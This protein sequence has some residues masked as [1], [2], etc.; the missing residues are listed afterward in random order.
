MTATVRGLNARSRFLSRAARFGSGC[1]VAAFGVGEH[2]SRVED[3]EAVLVG[4]DR[5]EIH[6]GDLRMRRRRF[7]RRFRAATRSRRCRRRADRG[8]RAESE[9][10]EAARAS[11]TPRARQ[12]APAQARCPSSLRRT[13]RRA[14]PS[15]SGRIVRRGTSPRSAR[16]P[17]WPSAERRRPRSA[18]RAPWRRRLRRIRSNASRT[19]AS[20]ARLSSTPP[21]SLLWL[22][23]GD[24]TFSTTGNPIR[25]A[26]C[27]AS[28]AEAAT[29][30]TTTGR[31]SE[32]RIRLLSI[33]VRTDRPL[34][35]ADDI[36][37]ETIE[38]VTLV[39]YSR[40]RELFEPPGSY[41]AR[42]RAESSANAVGIAG[43]LSRK[44]GK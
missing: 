30:G 37:D 23:S 9:R 35:R 36:T 43:L 41:A 31:P 25:D 28:S 33:S 34:E 14:R 6:L 5:I 13:L 40:A 10:R 11:Q 42:P 22:T 19:A 8:R 24:S 15:P 29:S 39:A 20:S 27:T 32:C 21:T 38:S 17:A 7:P 26:A 2:D 12:S 4:D 44:M 18:R 1:G 16:R 3:R